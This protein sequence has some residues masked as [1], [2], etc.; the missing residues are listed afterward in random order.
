[1]KMVKIVEVYRL[2]TVLSVTEKLYVHVHESDWCKLIEMENHGW[3]DL[4]SINYSY[5]PFTHIG[6][7]SMINPKCHMVLKWISGFILV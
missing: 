5:K 4:M 2:K 3:I 1:M 6:E 7:L